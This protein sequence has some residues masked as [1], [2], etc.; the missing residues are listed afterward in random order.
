MSRYQKGKT[1]LDFTE[2]RVSEWQ[3]HQLGHM[4]V[5]TS[6]QTDS[7]ASTPL[8]SFFAGR[9][10]FLMHN[11]LHQCTE[12]TWKMTNGLKE[13]KSLMLP[14]LQCVQNHK[15]LWRYCVFRAYTWRMWQTRW[16]FTTRRP[17]ILLPL[18]L[19]TQLRQPNSCLPA[20]LCST[21]R[22]GLHIPSIDSR[23]RVSGGPTAGTCGVRC[24]I[25][26]RSCRIDE[27]ET[28]SR[29]TLAWMH[30]CAQFSWTG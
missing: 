17:E 25:R 5:C 9:M 29:G 24:S 12:G 30:A 19:Q 23:C 21:H 16:N 7:H 13:E 3:W 1:S 4:Q 8:L 14:L 2:A 11:Q 26:R 28:C 15:V 20:S 18:P 27:T 10:P 6:L 22:C